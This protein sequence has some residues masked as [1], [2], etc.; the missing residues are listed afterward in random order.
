MSLTMTWSVIYIINLI[1]MVLDYSGTVVSQN[2]PY[3]EQGLYW[4]YN[5]RVAKRFEDIFDECPY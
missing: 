1:I 5:V 2:E 4:G 3:E